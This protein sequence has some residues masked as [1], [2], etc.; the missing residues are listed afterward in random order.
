MLKGEGKL[1]NTEKSFDLGPDVASTTPADSFLCLMIQRVIF[2]S[3]VI[4][5]LF[6]SV[7]K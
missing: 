2:L 6:H 3:E 1:A 7:Y 5:V 4:Q